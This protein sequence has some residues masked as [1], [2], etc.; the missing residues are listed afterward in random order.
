MNSLQSTL[1]IDFIFRPLILTE[2]QRLILLTRTAHHK[3]TPSTRTALRKRIPLT[4]TAHHRLLPFPP[5][6]Q[7]P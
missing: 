1:L 7:P 2:H 4:R 5:L 6:P 3:P